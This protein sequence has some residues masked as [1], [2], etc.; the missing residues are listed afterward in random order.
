M[1]LPTIV[2]L[3]GSARA[4]SRIILEND[5]YPLDTLHGFK[6]KVKDNLKFFS[7]IVDAVR[8]RLWTL[9]LVNMSTC[10]LMKLQSN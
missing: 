9:P 8:R 2:G 3:G 5:N 7:K 10:A 4:L 6:Y 1:K